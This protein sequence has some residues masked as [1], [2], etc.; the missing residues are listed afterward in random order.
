MR[1]GKEAQS[2]NL[3]MINMRTKTILE[4]GMMRMSAQQKERVKV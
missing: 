2:R 4:A 1:G 3:M